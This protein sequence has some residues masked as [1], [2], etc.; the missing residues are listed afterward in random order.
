MFKPK[1]NSVN[2]PRELESLG[3]SVKK[4]CVEGRCN[5]KPVRFKHKA[6]S[7]LQ[8]SP[9]ISLF[10]VII[11]LVKAMPWPSMDIRNLQSSWNL[12]EQH[13]ACNTEP[14]SQSPIQ[15]ALLSKAILI[16]KQLSDES[17]GM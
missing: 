2:S 10:P 3:K 5:K 7:F 15:G 16:I 6:W 14:F 4:F 1:Q 9:L 12:G 11:G 13:R 8:E 17:E